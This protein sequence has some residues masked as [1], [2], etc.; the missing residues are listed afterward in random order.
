MPDKTENYI[1]YMLCFLGLMIKL[2]FG[3][4][5]TPDGTNGPASSTMWG[6]GLII[7][8]LVSYFL[9]NFIKDQDKKQNIAP[10]E[11]EGAVEMVIMTLTKMLDFLKTFINYKN[12]SMAIM[13]MLFVTI[14]AFVINSV[15][16]T[17]INQGLVADDFY[18]YST[19][20]TVLI[21]VQLILLFR[22]M[23]AIAGGNPNDETVQNNNVRYNGFG[24]LISI[25]NLIFLGVINIILEYFSTDG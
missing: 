13:F 21:S 16:Y 19:M 10:K 15:Y 6:Y 8:C 4:Y 3:Q 1:F 17:R 25:I 22:H 11:N 20:S 24:F 14:W 5:S 7:I 23:T 12:N 2:F 9:I 18:F